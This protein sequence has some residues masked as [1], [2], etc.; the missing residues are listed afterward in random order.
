MAKQTVPTDATESNPHQ[1][2]LSANN[3]HQHH[4]HVDVVPHLHTED[5]KTKA[6]ATTLSKTYPMWPKDHHETCKGF[7]QD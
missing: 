7:K 3:P 4:R 6:W 5:N 2:G 1:F